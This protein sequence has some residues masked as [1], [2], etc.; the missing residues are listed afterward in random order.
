MVAHVVLLRTVVVADT[1][2]QDGHRTVL[3]DAVEEVPAVIRVVPCAAASVD[4]AATGIL[5]VGKAV[6]VAAKVVCQLVV[7]VVVRVAVQYQ[8]VA[9]CLHLYARITIAV[10]L[11][12]LE[13]T[14]AAAVVQG[15]LSRIADGQSL[16]VQVCGAVLHLYSPAAV[17]L[18]A[19]V[20]DGFLACYIED[21]HRLLLRSLLADVD[22][23]GKIILTAPAIEHVTGS[24]RLY[25]RRERARL[26]IRRT[27][28][29]TVGGTIIILG[30]TAHSGKSHHQHYEILLHC[31]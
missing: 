18:F 19:E 2:L 12:I 24:Y 25:Q 8:V 30:E 17:G 20:E 11:Q 16:D 13:G 7:E 4:V 21:A 27:V 9:A 10:G 3:T 26:L 29:R 31:L 14:V 22:G 6:G 15:I 1:V 28:T 23:I 5:L